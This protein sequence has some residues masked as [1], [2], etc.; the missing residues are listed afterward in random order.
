MWMKESTDKIHHQNRR[1][2]NIAFESFSVAFEMNFPG[3]PF[4]KVQALQSKGVA[5]DMS[6]VIA[7]D[8]MP[9]NWPDK[10]NEVFAVEE[11]AEAPHDQD[12]SSEKI[13]YESYSF[14]LGR[15]QVD[16]IPVRLKEFNFAVKYFSWGELSHLLGPV[17][18]RLGV[19][20]GMRGMRVHPLDA[21]GREMS[22]NGVTLTTDHSEALAFAGYDPERF[23][24][25]FPELTDA[26]EYVA[27]SPYFNPA[28]FLDKA[29]EDCEQRKD[30]AHGDSY[31]YFLEWCQA[32][33]DR[34]TQGPRLSR[35]KTLQRVFDHFPWADLYFRRAVSRMDREA[36]PEVSVKLTGNVMSINDPERVGVA[37]FAKEEFS[38]EKAFQDWVL[39]VSDSE[40]ES[41][42]SRRYQ[43]YLNAKKDNES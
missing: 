10:I 3:V 2:V 40:L 35:D 43:D 28:F 25:G 37:E 7:S 26:F 5:G 8:Q 41:W 36:E 15:I 31:Q 32:N 42:F 29:S 13:L 6:V 16:L 19:R 12:Y 1:E 9:A 33:R 24:M 14:N 18:G 34:L 21:S 27:S 4:A 22:K 38:S 11:S 23:E 39:T 30:R 20:Y 17:F